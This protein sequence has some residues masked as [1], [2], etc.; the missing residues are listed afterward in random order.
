MT[1][2]ELQIWCRKNPVK[3]SALMVGTLPFT[4]PA[5]LSAKLLVVLLKK[6]SSQE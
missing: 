2:D 3:A 6:T 4:V 5:W 1:P